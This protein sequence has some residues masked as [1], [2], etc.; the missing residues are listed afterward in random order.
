VVV[1]DGPPK[2]TGGLDTHGQD[3]NEHKSHL[4]RPA[5]LHVRLPL[6]HTSKPMREVSMECQREVEEA[7]RL[8]VDFDQKSID[9]T[10]SPLTAGHILIDFAPKSACFDAFPLST[11]RVETDFG[12][13]STDFVL[14]PITERLVEIDFDPKS[15]DFVP[16]PVN[17][18]LK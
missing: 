9:F 15:T 16:F 17:R 4:R 7:V 18:R 3:G 6:A 2:T 12:L 1:A 5:T 8:P 10:S 14:F 11:R 13:K